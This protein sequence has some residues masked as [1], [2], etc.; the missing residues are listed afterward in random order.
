VLSPNL[1]ND[2]V[3]AGNRNKSGRNRIVPVPSYVRDILVKGESHHNTSEVVPSTF[4]TN[5]TL[6]SP[7][8]INSGKTFVIP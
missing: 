2:T 3:L 4:N 8:T 6:Y 5:S 7:D 1:T